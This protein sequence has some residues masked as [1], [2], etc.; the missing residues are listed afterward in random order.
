[1]WER[2]GK[3]RDTTPL[4]AQIERLAGLS[5]PTNEVEPNVAYHL[6]TT[7]LARAYATDSKWRCL[8]GYLD[9]SGY[10]AGPRRELLDLFPQA[11]TFLEQHQPHDFP[12]GP[13]YRLW[14]LGPAH[15]DTLRPIV[16]IE[17]TGHLLHRDGS[18]TALD[19]DADLAAIAED[20]VP[21]A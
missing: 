1:M 8:N 2:L 15:R 21:A 17:S 3:S 19:H 13:A 10:S 11:P 20:I 9:S 16:A 5:T 7:I 4:V 12:G 18:T 14:F 6:I